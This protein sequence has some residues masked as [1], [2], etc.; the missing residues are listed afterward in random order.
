MKVVKIGGKIITLLDDGVFSDKT[1]SFWNFG[2]HASKG[3]NK[4]NKKCHHNQDSQYWDDL[5]FGWQE[6]RLYLSFHLKRNFKFSSGSQ[7]CSGADSAD[8]VVGSSGPSHSFTRDWCIQLEMPEMFIAVGLESK[9]LKGPF[10]RELV[11]TQVT[12]LSK[13]W[14]G[15]VTL[16]GF[17]PYNRS[18]AASYPREGVVW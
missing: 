10:H 14:W 12:H 3:Q 1:G 18:E 16:A 9:T 7:E 17:L 4:E 11:E 8:S 15:L 13:F 2:W 5:P 6:R